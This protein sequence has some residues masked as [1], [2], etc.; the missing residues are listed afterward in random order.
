MT[1]SEVYN[2]FIVP[3]HL[4]LHMQRVAA[5]GEYLSNNWK[6]E[7]DRNDIVHTLLLH[8]LGNLLKFD[9]N[10]G[11][12]LFH[13]SERD[14]DYWKKAQSESATKYDPD[15][16]K[17]TFL[18][19]KEVGVSERVLFLLNNMGSSNLQQTLESPDWELKI[20]SYSD[21]RVGPHGYLTVRKRFEDILNRY[22]G[23]QH[24]LANEQKT[25]KKMERCL[26]LEE[27]LHP[28]SQVNLVKLPESELEDRAKKLSAAEI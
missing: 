18:M 21:F 28:H 3:R 15:E 16:H 12:G 14:L 20:C 27:Q 25:Q 5:L 1:I 6:T 19:A 11:V 26:Q 9:L 24:V 7:I 2:H 8:D 17:A 13:P 23:R 4:Q 22:K 10:R